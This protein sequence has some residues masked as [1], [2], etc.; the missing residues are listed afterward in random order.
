MLD[1][2]STDRQRFLAIA[3]GI[4]AI[5]GCMG[6][7]S[8][9]NTDGAENETN[10]TGGT[11]DTNDTAA[12]EDSE[13]AAEEERSDEDTLLSVSNLSDLEALPFDANIVAEFEGE[14]STV[15]DRFA[16]DSGLTMFVYES[17]NIEGQGLGADFEQ[18]DGDES[19]VLVINEIVFY[20]EEDEIDEV[21]G[22]SIVEAGGGEY[23]LDIDT[24]GAWTIHI[25]QPRAPSEEIRTLPVSA[26]GEDAAV[27]GPVEVENGMTITGQHQADNDHTFNVRSV[28]EDAT[29]QLDGDYAFTEDAGFEGQSRVDVDGVTWTHIGTRGEWSLEFEE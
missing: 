10:D 15:T 1:S 24:D 22:A 28:P 9:E 17:E 21:T 11:Q 2:N 25:A 6:G 18:T 23:L 14:G 16:L 4:A 19:Y 29:N 7:N 3:G 20:E 5:A 26:S 13:D 12:N 8:E 27:V